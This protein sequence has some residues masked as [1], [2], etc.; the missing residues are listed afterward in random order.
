MYRDDLNNQLSGEGEDIRTKH[1][2]R[3]R[4]LA[5]ACSVSVK[6]ISKGLADTVTSNRASPF[7]QEEAWKGAKKERAFSLPDSEL[8]VAVFCCYRKPSQDLCASKGRART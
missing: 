6:K 5:K 3:G 8:F 1:W 7:E 2:P 4:L